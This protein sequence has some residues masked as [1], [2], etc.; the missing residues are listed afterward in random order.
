MY[1]NTHIIVQNLG[2]AATT[3]RYFSHETIKQMKVLN[4]HEQTLTKKTRKQL[5]NQ[6]NQK[7]KK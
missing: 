1:I 4:K 3:P 7:T 5:I 2:V 6:F